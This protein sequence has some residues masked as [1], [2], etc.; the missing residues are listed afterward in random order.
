MKPGIGGGVTSA[1]LFDARTGLRDSDLTALKG[2][3][4]VEALDLDQ[5]DAITDRG[6]SA[7]RPLSGLKELDLS[8]NR[9][10]VT[11]E[12]VQ[13][14]LSDAALVHVGKLSNLRQL[15]LAGNHITDA[16]LARL[17]GLAHLEYLDLRETLVTDAGL[18]PL[19]RL[20]RLK[21]LRAAKTRITPEGAMALRAV[22]PE[23][24]VVI[25]SEP[26]AGAVP[27]GR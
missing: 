14:K 9:L 7:L 21:T 23:V 26:D 16:G 22:L 15:T 19:K 4:N 8:R 1:S 5:C 3:R 27:D 11:P 12:D 17:T 10:L 6:L 18:E 2:L 20:K 13:P 24:E 25:V